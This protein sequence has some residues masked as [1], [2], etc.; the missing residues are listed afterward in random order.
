MQKFDR[1]GETSAAIIFGPQEFLFFLAVQKIDGAAEISASINIWFHIHVSLE[2]FVPF[3][4]V[5]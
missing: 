2:K 3:Q 1:A 5:Q 4:A